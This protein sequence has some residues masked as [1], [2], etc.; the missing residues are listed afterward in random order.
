[1]KPRKVHARAMVVT[2]MLMTVLLCVCAQLTAQTAAPPTASQPPSAEASWPRRFETNGHVVLL[3][4]P[5]VDSWE[6][7]AKIAFR[8]AVAVLP[9]GKKEPVYGVIDVAAD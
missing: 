3:Y 1:M 9:S 8:A 6:H 2:A 5:Q 4:Q 7:Y